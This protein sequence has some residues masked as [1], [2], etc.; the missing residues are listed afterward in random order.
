MK[1]WKSRKFVVFAVS[2]LLYS[3]NIALGGLVDEETLSQMIALVIGWL[4]AQ[5]IADSGWSSASGAAREVVGEISDAVDS[6][7]QV[8]TESGDD[9]GR[10]QAPAAT[11]TGD[12]KEPESS[13]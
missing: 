7:R 12:G 8:L 5:G 2:A 9:S 10:V 3:A 6:V 13:D 4:V 1:S 11:E